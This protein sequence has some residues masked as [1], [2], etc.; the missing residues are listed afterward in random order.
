M[1]LEKLKDKNNI[2][3]VQKVDIYRKE[4]EPPVTTTDNN[5]VPTTEK[6]KKLKKKKRKKNH[7]KKIRKLEKR[8]YKNRRNN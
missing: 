5:N 3:I 1:L 8:N 6:K 7:Q 2:S 4:P